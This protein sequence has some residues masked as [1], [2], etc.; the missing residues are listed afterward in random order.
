MR[1]ALLA[2]RIWLSERL[3]IEQGVSRSHMGLRPVMR[4]VV[5]SGALNTAF[6]ITY[7]AVLD[8]KSPLS[9]GALPI[10]SDMVSRNT[11]SMEN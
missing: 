1:P 4:I 3:I 6:L 10:V 8:S 7:M 5:E 11:R 9:A 2:Y